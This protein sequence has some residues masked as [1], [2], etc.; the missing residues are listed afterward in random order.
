[1]KQNVFIAFSLAVIFI[2]MMHL[3]RTVAE[4]A[5]IAPSYRQVRSTNVHTNTGSSI[6]EDDLRPTQP[7]S[8]TLANIE[9]L[10]N[11]HDLRR[12]VYNIDP[13]AYVKFS[14]VDVSRLL[15]KDF[16]TDLRGAE[17]RIL[18]FHTH[19]QETFADSREG[20][21]ED[22]IVGVGDVLARILVE[23]YG[24]SVVHD[25]GVYD[26]VDG[27]I[28]RSVS[29]QTMEP[30]VRSLLQKYPSIEVA[31]DLHRDGVPDNVRLVTQINGKPTARI[32]FFNGITRMNNN[33]IPQEMPH[34]QNPYLFENL[35][36][37]LQMQLRANKLYPGFARRI[38]IK[39]Y[40]YSLHLLP[41]S[42]LIE[43]GANTSTVEEAK[44]AMEPLARLLVDV[45]SGGE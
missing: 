41:K 30:A 44:N 19:S 42:L 36:L 29:Y 22:T 17:P 7:F 28:D 32:M 6:T 31:I 14:D 16:N 25:R 2:C 8:P 5:G 33:G 11:M 10:N 26:F 23:R 34:L 37:S 15:T 3:S 18:I 21:A 13:T 39:P 43:V 24:I 4:P 40:R 1:M 38:Y 9:R 45:L 12:F 35:A 27:K 20:Y